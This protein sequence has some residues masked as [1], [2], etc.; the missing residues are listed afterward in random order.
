MEDVI[1]PVFVIGLVVLVLASLWRIFEKAGR[2]GWEGIIPIYNIYVILKIVGKPGWWL[3]LF[4]VPIVNFVI[5]IV[6]YIDLAKKFGKGTG[7]GLGLVFLGFIFLPILAFGDAQYQDGNE[8]YDDVISD[9]G[10]SKDQDM[11]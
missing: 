10:A 5:Q 3:L 9:I 11:P 4:L 2:Q 6:V 8:N 1:G 7:F